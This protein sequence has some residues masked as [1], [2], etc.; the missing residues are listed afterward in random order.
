MSYIYGHLPNI[1]RTRDT[2]YLRLH[3]SGAGYAGHIDIAVVNMTVDSTVTFPA[4]RYNIEV[5]L[6]V[7]LPAYSMIFTARGYHASTI[8][9]ALGGDDTLPT[10]AVQGPPGIPGPK[11]DDGKEGRPGFTGPPGPQGPPGVQGLQGAPGPKGDTGERGPQG[12]KGDKGDTGPHGERG[13]A[14]FASEWVYVGKGRPDIPE[15]LGT[16]GAAWVE[17]CPVGAIWFP[18]D[19]PAGAHILQSDEYEWNV[20]DGSTGTVDK[21]SS[22]DFSRALTTKDGSVS[23]TKPE[24]I[25]VSRTDELITLDTTLT[26]T[27]PG[28]GTFQL[29]LPYCWRPATSTTVPVIN[30]TGA[31]GALT[32]NPVNPSTIN[33]TTPGNVR[34]HAVYSTDD[35][36]PDTL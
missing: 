31:V 5:C 24:H 32:L 23:L 4:G 17:K 34:I 15:T 36:W 3:P 7:N 29:S 1:E 21:S 8:I 26:A 18:I 30:S 9:P 11:G 13:P 22:Y 12:P 14:G 16:D 27:T 10:L 33:T 28:R 35:P 19:D 20:I 25:W 2:G 6:G